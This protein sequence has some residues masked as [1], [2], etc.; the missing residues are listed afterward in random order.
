MK[1]IFGD[2]SK[3]NGYPRA[4]TIDRGAKTFFK[5]IRGTKTS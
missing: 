3:F 4:G 2:G 5:Q 1:N